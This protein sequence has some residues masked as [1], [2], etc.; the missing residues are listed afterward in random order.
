M[1]WGKLF[2]FFNWEWYV[3]EELVKVFMVI[4]VFICFVSVFVLLFVIV[5]WIVFFVRFILEEV[6]VRL[7][8]I[9]FVIWLMVMM[10]GVWVGMVIKGN[11]K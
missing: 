8:G 11:L 9:D 5:M 6:C 1:V 7:F 2:G 4:I 10:M 3:G